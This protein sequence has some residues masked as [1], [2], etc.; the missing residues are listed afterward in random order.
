MKLEVL[1]TTMHQT[2]F[3]K[4]YDMI[5]STN[6][7]IAN[8]ADCNCE[9]TKIIGGHTVKLITTHTRGLSLNRN[10]AISNIS[11]TTEY[12]IFAIIFIAF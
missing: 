11:N 8:Q 10:T 3:S 5:L 6:A 9:E 4:Y 7:V 12:I 2:D 1:V